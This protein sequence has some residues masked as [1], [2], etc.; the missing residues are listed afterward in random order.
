MNLNCLEKLVLE[1]SPHPVEATFRLD[2]IKQVA[3]V[4]IL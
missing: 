3:S 2:S 1:L 4:K